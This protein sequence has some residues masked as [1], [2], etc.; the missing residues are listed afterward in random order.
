M[1]ALVVRDDKLQEQE[2]I[3]FELEFFAGLSVEERFRLV[4]ERSKLLVEM[5][6]QNGHPI[7]PGVVKRR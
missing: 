3:R 6:A 5:L 2:Q 7:T 1:K 4:L